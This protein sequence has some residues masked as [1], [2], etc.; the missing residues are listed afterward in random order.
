[1]TLSN[2][3]LEVFRKPFVVP[4]N[5]ID[6]FVCF[7]KFVE[8]AVEIFPPDCIV[9]GKRVQSLNELPDRYVQRFSYFAVQMLWLFPVDR[10]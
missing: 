6:G 9:S 5:I 8:S 3:Y 4:I 7:A 2:S 10:L 1:M